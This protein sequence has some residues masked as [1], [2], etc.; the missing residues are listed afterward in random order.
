MITAHFALSEF[1]SNANVTR[2]DTVPGTE[3]IPLETRLALQM[4]EEPIVWNWPTPSTG[5]TPPQAYNF[6]DFM[7]VSS[8]DG[9]TYFPSSISFSEGYRTFLMLIDR[10]KYPDQAT[11]DRA[12][13]SN[14]PSSP[15]SP[16]LT[17]IP[18]G[19]TRVTEVTGIQV[20]KPG[21]SIPLYPTDWIASVASSPLTLDLLGN[22]IAL[23]SGRIDSTA[24]TKLGFSAAAWGVIPISPAAWFFGSIVSTVK[25]FG[26]PYQGATLTNAGIF[27]SGGLLPCRV[28]Q[29]I[30]ALDPSVDIEVQNTALDGGVPIDT[31]SVAGFVFDN[32][33]FDNTLPV[34]GT[35]R[36]GIA[37][38]MDSASTTRIKAQ[39][40]GD[41]QAFIIAVQV[42]SMWP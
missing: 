37:T 20:A 18:P 28:A 2:L 9:Q 10:G 4:L 29:F 15:L 24:V 25:L 6:F 5:T 26:G 1:L 30:V 41:H 40:T 12:I 11:L 21:W 31:I 39:A 33:P 35:V 13:E 36:A 23:A 34:A 27:G 32:A 38:E 8:V 3:S 17:T 14:P 22:E 42:E 16:G 7:P 19:W